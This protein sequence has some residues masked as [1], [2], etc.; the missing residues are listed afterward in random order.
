M[1]YIIRS[2]KKEDSLFLSETVMKALGEELCNN[3]S[4]GQGNRVTTLFEHLASQEESQYS[5]KNSLLAISSDGKRIGAIIG[6][7]GAELRKL[8]KAFIKAANEI[9]GWNFNDEDEKNMKDEADPGEIYL[10]SLYVRPEFR[11]QSIGSALINAM[12]EKLDYLKKPF[13]LLVDPKKI[14]TKKIYEHLGFKDVGINGVFGMDM[15][16]MQ[17]G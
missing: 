13:G 7:D 2:G 12:I 8:R 14:N 16:H 9:L 10:D 6:Y 15:I 1:D 5:Y 4:G 3:L 17:K 11:K